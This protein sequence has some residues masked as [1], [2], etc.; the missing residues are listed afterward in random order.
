VNF[1]KSGLLSMKFFKNSELLR[2]SRLPL[3]EVIS[4]EKIVVLVGD[5]PIILI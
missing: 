5:F 4:G 3:D 1:G 2:V